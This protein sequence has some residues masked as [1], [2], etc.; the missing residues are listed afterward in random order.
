M[1][2]GVLVMW[3][4]L[5]NAAWTAAASA[6]AFNKNN[7]NYAVASNRDTVQKAR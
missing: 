5:G 2:V 1:L 7:G 6:I 4:L 3:L